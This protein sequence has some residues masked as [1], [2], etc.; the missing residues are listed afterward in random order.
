M[1]LKKV[2]SAVSG[3]EDH[4]VGLRKRLKNLLSKNDSSDHMQ[5]LAWSERA[6]RAMSLLMLGTALAQPALHGC[7]DKDR[8][9]DTGV[10]LPEIE[11]PID[12]DEDAAV[13]RPPTSNLDDE[14]NILNLEPTKG[15]GATVR[16]ITQAMQIN[17]T[18]DAIPIVFFNTSNGWKRCAQV[19]MPSNRAGDQSWW[20]QARS[21]LNP[22]QCGTVDVNRQLPLGM[23]WRAEHMFAAIRHNARQ[24][25]HANER[26]NRRTQIRRAF[27]E[28]AKHTELY[29]Y[30][31]H[32]S[33]DLAEQFVNLVCDGMPALE[34]EYGHH[35]E[36]SR[37]GAE[38]IWQIEPPTRRDA[39]TYNQRAWSEIFGNRTP[40]RNSIADESRV[41]ALIFNN[42]FRHYKSVWPDNH[43]V[44][45]HPE[46][47][48]IP[49]LIGGYNPGQGA[50]ERM[51]T[52]ELTDPAVQAILASNDPERIQNEAYI[53]ASTNYFLR[54]PR[55]DYGTASLGYYPKVL[56]YHALF[57]RDVPGDDNDVTAN[58]IDPPT[59]AGGRTQARNF[60]NNLH[61][62]NN[63][64]IRRV[65]SASF[66]LSNVSIPRN[67]NAWQ[68]VTSAPSQNNV[69]VYPWLLQHDPFAA[70]Y[71]NGFATNIALARTIEQEVT[72]GNLIRE[73]TRSHPELI[74]DSENIAQPWRRVVRAD[75]IS[76]I[77]KLITELN[78]RLYAGGLGPDY[79]VVPIINSTVRSL[80][81]H[82]H[83]RGHSNH[84]AHPMFAAIDFSCRQ[85]AVIHRKVDGSY[86]RFV[87]DANIGMYFRGLVQA[88]A[89]LAQ[90]VRDRD[91][92]AV[93][94]GDI[95]VR[96]HG[97]PQHFHMVIRNRSAGEQHVHHAP[98]APRRPATVNNRPQ[99]A[100][101][102][103]APG[104]RRPRFPNRRLRPQ[105]RH[106]TLRNNRNRPGLRQLPGRGRHPQIQ[107]NRTPARRPATLHRR[108]INRRGRRR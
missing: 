43:P 107:N 108:V 105:L 41:V 54:H 37:T 27:L 80:A 78:A 6:R 82:G 70:R 74:F 21:R 20:D 86:E 84:S 97:P 76:T 36:T 88:S 91:T 72:A 79:M 1:P 92:G 30:L 94:Q 5:Q 7:T 10:Q 53:T 19:N 104:L 68:F 98:T 71:R 18:G 46:A 62:R 4:T 90:P 100:N 81:D 38:G 93:Q 47:L 85:Y 40:N 99:V 75:H 59:L 77:N 22:E 101:H 33:P 42:I 15:M 44:F 3:S 24:P 45:Q 50:V 61:Q 55:S 64:D 17:P 83:L 52:E 69:N 28:A 63:S 2:D 9:V 29:Q 14:V 35:I 31:N 58:E 66:N 23:P 102:P 60:L 48:L 67:A 8:P 57:E 49:A 39:H 32:Y 95:F 103:T 56:A 34:T 11:D 51:M 25:M 87:T 13:T 106:P 26:I 73:N 89:R 65:R 96:F 12:D 16:S